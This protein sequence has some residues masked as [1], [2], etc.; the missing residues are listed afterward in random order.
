M[1]RFINPLLSCM[2]LSAAAAS[3]ESFENIPAGPLTSV[4]TA[5]GHWTAEVRHASVVGNR[6]HSGTHSLRL[7]EHGNARVV[8]ELATPTTV[9]VGFSCFAER[10]TKRPPFEFTLEAK[11]ADAW[12]LLHR[13]APD[14]VKVGGFLANVRTKLPVGTHELRFSCGS[15]EDGGILLDDVTISEPGPLHATQVTTTQPVCPVMLRANFNPVL[16]FCITVTGSE[17]SLKLDG[18]ELGMD[19]SSHPADIERVKIF[20]GT[21]APLDQGTDLVAETTHTNGKISLACKRDLVPGDNW[22]WISPV[23]HTNADIDGRID[24]SL[25]RVKVGGIV[26]E[27]AVPSPAGS[28]RIGVAVKLPGDDRSKAFR[29]PNLVRTKKG[30]LLA[31]YDVRYRHAG[32]LPADIDIGVS[33]SSDGGRSW[34]PMHLALD[35]GNDPK[36]SYDGVGDP[37]TLVD[38]LS[39]RIWI[40]AS[41][42]HGKLGWNGSKPGLAPEATHQLMMTWSDDD[43][44][45][46]AKPRNLTNELKNPAWRLMLQGP[47]AGITMKDGTLVMPA[48]YR[49]ADGPP[50]QGKPFSTLICSSD[51]GKSWHIGT[52]V[53]SDTT[54]AQIAELADGSLMINCRDNRGGS[55]TVAVTRDL[56]QTW[57]P[58]PTDRKAL[59]EPVCMA[60]LMRWQH[61]QHGDLMFFSNPD[62]TDGRHNM[63]VKLSNDQAL[64]W[65]ESSTRMY[66]SRSCFGY[67]CLSIADAQHLGVL[68]EGSGSILF[69]RLPLSEWFH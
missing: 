23:L 36:F 66:D 65:P 29:I 16:G 53:K 27:P 48:Q 21:S 42:S 38:E 19:G 56:G 62:A 57:T 45:T 49:A 59:R 31:V 51:H 39:G 3:G 54:E 13:A 37:C 26:I 14:E 69:L 46:W 50:D 11:V 24:A 43:G 58:H 32:D 33:R 7:G 68:Y 5:L 64:T 30:S 10:W 12:Q 18:L 1:L 15:D 61:P 20:A 67:S 17:G 25:W 2:L 60:S 44:R 35:M 8:L 6:G 41:W 47:G 52:G 34:E 40:A 28:Q 63:S 22:F 9:G 4:T 55:R